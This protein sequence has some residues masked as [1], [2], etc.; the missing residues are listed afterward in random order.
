MLKGEQ[1]PLTPIIAISGNKLRL[2]CST[3]LS[4]PVSWKYT[5]VGHSE[6]EFLF[7]AGDLNYKYWDRYSIDSSKRGQ[8]DIIIKQVEMKD[9]GS[10]ICTERANF[11]DDLN[12]IELN[13]VGK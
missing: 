5:Q 1:I 4:I 7:H 12:A 2:N 13:V 3:V 8:Y 10:Y 9:G 6:K 11:G